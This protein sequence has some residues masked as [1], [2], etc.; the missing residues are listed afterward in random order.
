[1]QTQTVVDLSAVYDPRRNKKQMVF[2]TAI[3]TYKLFGGAMGGGKTAALINEGQQLN[4]DYKGNVG[5]LLRKT[6][7]SFRLTV[8]P[9]M[10]RFIDNKLIVNW[11]QSSKEIIYKNG[12]ILWYG[13]FG[14]N[15]D[16]WQKFMSGEYGWIAIDQAEE[17]AENDFKMLATRLRLNVPNISY[18]FL[19]SCNPNPGWIKER[20]I[21]R[22]I[23]D[24]VFIP[25]LP[26]DNID[27]LPKDYIPKMEALLDDNQRKALLH[28]DWSAIDEPDCPY[29]NESIRQAQK[30]EIPAS[31]PI[32]IGCDVAR[33]GLNET[34]ICYKEGN[35]VSLYSQ[36][37]GHD[38]MRTAGNIWQC[39]IELIEKWKD[40]IADIKIRVDADGLGAGVV[41][42]L[43]EEQETKE[44][45]LKIKIEIIEIHGSAKSSDSVKYKNL[46]AD[47]HWQL[48]EQLTGL[49]LP[50]ERELTSQLMGIKYF[51]NSAGQIQ[52]VAKEK[53]KEKLGRS[54]DVA[55]AVI[56]TVTDYESDD[57]FLGA[58][59]NTYY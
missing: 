41:D 57:V 32:S 31:L 53:I 25:S 51:V 14:D 15:P 34:V 10:K 42:R 18:H 37:Q 16:D 39:V 21:E 36:A 19:L 27:N 43:N 56:Y 58:S 49:D 24:H 52:I 33:G 46:R 45:E 35:K 20:F 22:E 55:E 44:K 7:P 13:S 38:T 47:L 8:L 4:L 3:E 12:S 11:N 1:M 54:P 50:D 28:G 48:R 29:D 30:R 59:K 5:L 23:K 40:K 9:Q 6:F 17:F 2:H 26:Q